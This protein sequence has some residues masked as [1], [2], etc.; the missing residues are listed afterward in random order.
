MTTNKDLVFAIS[1]IIWWLLLIL[2]FF[3][4]GLGGVAVSHFV[5]IV[6]Y[7]IMIIFK[8]NNRKFGNWLEKTI[9]R[10]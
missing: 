10:K 1:V 3:L 8:F 7:G 5:C 4:F 9:K 2:S 6:L